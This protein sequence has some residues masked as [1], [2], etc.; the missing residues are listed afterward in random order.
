M[1]NSLDQLRLIV[2]SLLFA[3]DRALTLR[4]LHGILSDYT[5]GEIKEALNELIKEYTQLQRSFELVEVA[6]GYLFRTKKEYGEYL[7]RLYRISPYKLSAPAMETLA[8][9]AYKQPITKYEIESIR[10]VDVTHILKVLMEKGL[11]RIVG[12]KDIAGRPLLYGTTRRFLEVFG[13]KDLST[14][15]DIEEVKKG[16]PTELPFLGTPK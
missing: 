14:L 3:S 12:K 15:P 1:S 6:E 16:L 7:R 4:D 11:V 10:G 5:Y 8:I 9:I 2:E 13:L